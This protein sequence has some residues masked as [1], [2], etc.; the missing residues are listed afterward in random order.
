MTLPTYLEHG[1][2]WRKGFRLY[3]IS[4]VENVYFYAVP[5]RKI[6]GIIVD[7]GPTEAFL[8]KEAATWEVVFASPISS[9]REIPRY[10][11]SISAVPPTT[12]ERLNR[13]PAF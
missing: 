5:V 2:L 11:I 6:D 9:A 1:T 13:E 3:Y 12:W 10:S 8:H 7:T 4:T